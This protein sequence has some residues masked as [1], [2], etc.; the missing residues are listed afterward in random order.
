MLHLKRYASIH[1]IDPAAWDSILDD[2]DIFHRHRFIKLVEDSKVENAEF[3]YLA[4]YDQQK[5]V[6]TTVLSAFSI[7]L[8][9]F[10]G[11]S[12]LAKAVKKIFPKLFSIKIL[13]GGLP[14]SFGQSNLKWIDDTYTTELTRL[15]ADEM[16]AVAEAKK[17]KFLAIKEFAGPEAA[18]LKGFEQ[19]GFFLANS[20]PYMYIDIGWDS[21][22]DYLAA[23]RHPYRRKI[24]LSLKKAGHTEP[25]ITPL[26]NYD[27][28]TDTAAWVLA[29]PGDDFANDFFPTYLRVM[30]RT[31][32]KLETLNKAFFENMQ[33]Q[34]E[35]YQVLHF[36]AKGKL[37]STAVL[38]F[39]GDTLTF[40][41]VGRENEKDGYDSY[42]NLVYGILALA[43]QRGVRRLKLGQTAYW[44]KKC[45]GG[46]AEDEFLYFAS[47]RPLIHRLLKRF[48]NALFPETDLESLHVFHEKTGK[49]EM[50][51]V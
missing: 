4:F 11:N 30:E 33:Q 3:S 6:A 29:S 1:A 49:A 48:K 40:M 31:P 34:K 18:A 37:L 35:D 44:V 12:G 14:A 41:L 39:S 26:E 47:R 25:V 50:Q 38:V 2:T 20:I 15:I 7:S 8:D 42:F 28:N 19:K 10:I 13:V 46:I 9:L 45:I 36:I 43:I 5:L 22:R 24:L 27:G 17:I 51:N 32:V 23:L 21:F 16:Y